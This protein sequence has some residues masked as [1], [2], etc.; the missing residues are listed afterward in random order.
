MAGEERRDDSGTRE[1]LVAVETRLGELPRVRERL[2]ELAE[3]TQELVHAEEAARDQRKETQRRLE[4]LSDRMT[5]ATL[6]S[7][8]VETALGATLAL[9]IEQ[10]KTDKAEIKQLVQS[11]N[12]EHERMHAENR[13]EL[14]DQRKQ[15]S[16]IEVRVAAY[17]GGAVVATWLLSHVLGL[18]AKYLPSLH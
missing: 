12:V 17:A 6:A 18:A 14:Q 4:V 3:T 13:A 11:Q 2:H 5:E 9:H 10:C 7:A 8:R 1:R 16:G 15:L